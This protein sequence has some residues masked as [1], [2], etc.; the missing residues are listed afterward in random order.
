MNKSGDTRNSHETWKCYKP[1]Y[2]YGRT[3]DWILNDLRYKG[4][5]EKIS[6][7]NLVQYRYCLLN[8][9]LNTL[10]PLQ[11]CRCQII[12][13]L[14]YLHLKFVY[15]LGH[16]RWI[17][18]ISH[19]EIS[20]YFNLLCNYSQNYLLIIISPPST[21]NPTNTFSFPTVQLFP[22]AVYRDKPNTAD[23]SRYRCNGSNNRHADI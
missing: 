21:K 9:I 17:S 16:I 19:L 15:R 22:V 8:G 10:A 4:Q 20:T 11:L 5:K 18:I 13:I 7:K 23:I 6:C 14:L 1:E 2:H 3:Q 12:E